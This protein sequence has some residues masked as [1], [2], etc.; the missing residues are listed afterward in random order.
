MTARD[1]WFAALEEAFSWIAPLPDGR[2]DST[3]TCAY[4]PRE[5]Y[6]RI[7]R[8]CKF[9]E[10]DPAAVQSADSRAESQSALNGPSGSPTSP[11]GRVLSWEKLPCSC[12]AE[13]DT[14]GNTYITAEG[15]L[16]EAKHKQGYLV[17]DAKP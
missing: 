10:G 1:P 8:A 11:S 12:L 13:T 14:E 2:D 7:E 3:A 5:V 16:C 17:T 9:P 4:V 6:A 15:Y